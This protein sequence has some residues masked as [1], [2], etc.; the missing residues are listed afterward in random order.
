MIADEVQAGFGRCGTLFGFQHYG[1][2]PDLVCGGK[3]ISS[4][5]PIS[6]VLGRAEIVDL[7][8]PGEM[9]STHTGNPICSAAALANLKVIVEEKLASNAAARGEEMLAGLH[10]IAQ[11]Y[12]D[13]VG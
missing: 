13:R 12:P 1:I 2:V 6:C 8:G 5:L 7:Y 10:K 9:T 3:G 11:K 4:S